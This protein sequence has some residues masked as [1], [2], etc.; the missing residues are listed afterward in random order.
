MVHDVEY[1]AA[2]PAT[3]KSKTLTLFR[4]SL[5][6]CTEMNQA[7]IESIELDI[8]VARFKLGNKEDATEELRSIKAKAAQIE[9]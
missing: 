5:G 7:L 8:R 6:T 9:A 2:T 1:Q 3:V 4:F